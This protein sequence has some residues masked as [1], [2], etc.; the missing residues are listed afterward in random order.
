MFSIRE[1]SRM[2]SEDMSL[3]TQGILCNPAFWAA[4]HLRSPAMI[5]KR[6]PLRRTTRGCMMPLCRID[7][8]S[9]SSLFSLKMLRGCSPVGSRRS[10]SSSIRSLST[11]VSCVKRA[12]SPLP[13]A[14]LDIVYHLLCQP[15][16][17]LGPLGSD[18]IKNNG[19]SVAW[20]FGESNVSQDNNVEY[21][22]PKKV[23]QVEH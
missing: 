9:S 19:F 21:L 14:F 22:R 1:I 8:A 15:H 17:A 5:S 11:D 20:G 6:S 7:C 10:I 2:F 18:V 12:S 16:V 23:P 4:R 13:S 3:T